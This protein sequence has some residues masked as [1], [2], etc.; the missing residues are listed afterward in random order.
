MHAVSIVLMAVNSIMVMFLSFWKGGRL[1]HIVA[2]AVRK[3][4]VMI[5]TVVTQVCKVFLKLQQIC[6]MFQ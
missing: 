3:L 2:T 4:V 6:C 1:P 5:V